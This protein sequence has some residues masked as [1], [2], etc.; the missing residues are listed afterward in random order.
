MT[1]YQCK[2]FVEGRGFV[3]ALCAEDL[4]GFPF[5]GDACDGFDPDAAGFVI[6][7]DY[8][9]VLQELSREVPNKSKP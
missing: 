1:C 6:Q 7:Q 5:V 8:E 4:K 2:K 9:Q 3:S